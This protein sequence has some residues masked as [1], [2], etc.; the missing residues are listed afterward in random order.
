MLA[1]VRSSPP[2]SMSAK[3]YRA[4][5]IDVGLN[6]TSAGRFFGTHGVTGR[7]W[8]IT[9]PPHVVAKFLRVM[10]V[11]RLTADDVEQL[12]A[13]TVSQPAAQA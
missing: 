5:L 11:Q 7:R 4:A 2:K 1:M 13:G 3:Q 6:Q 10:L 12:L 8:A 9:G